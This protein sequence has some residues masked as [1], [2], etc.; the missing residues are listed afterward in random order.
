MNNSIYEKIQAECDRQDEKWGV[1][2]N[3]PLEWLTILYEETGEVAMEVN[4]A[5]HDVAN[6]DIDKYETELVQC[7]AVI[8]QMLKNISQ[9]KIFKTS[10]LED[11]AMEALGVQ[12]HLEKTTDPELTKMEDEF[13]KLPVN[14]NFTI[15]VGST[16]LLNGK[17]AGY[18]NT[19]IKAYII[20]ITDHTIFYKNLDAISQ[21]M[22]RMA[23]DVFNTKY[24][25]IEQL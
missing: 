18:R 21:P 7:G 22:T 1:R 10:V 19:Y 2:N 11:R 9:Y 4:D 25:V 20:E 13:E 8:T 3:H 14:N 5:G 24:K 15:M 12:E 16:Y 23:I 17:T 6:L